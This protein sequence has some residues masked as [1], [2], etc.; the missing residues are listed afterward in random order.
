MTT[1]SL[2]PALVSADRLRRAFE[3][4]RVPTLVISDLG[5]GSVTVM[6]QGNAKLAWAKDRLALADQLCRGWDLT[7]EAR[8]AAL[9]VSGI[10]TPDLDDLARAAQ[11][12]MRAHLA[13][14]FE[15]AE[16]AVSAA[17][18]LAE[19]GKIEVQ[20][21]ESGLAEEM[22]PRVARWLVANGIQA[23]T[24]GGRSVW[25]GGKYAVVIKVQ[26]DSRKAA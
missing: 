14:R 11:V 15:S 26:R 19:D 20:A 18:V 8:G 23:E 13:T 10:H 3:A 7:V 25:R 12:A 6:V 4:R 9:L 24:D 21:A 1:A 22:G 16:R 2:A 5:P 17:R